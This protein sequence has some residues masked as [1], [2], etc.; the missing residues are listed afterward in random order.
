MYAI[1]TDSTD[2]FFNLALE[3]TLFETLHPGHPGMLLAW[4]NAPSII[5]GRHQNTAGEVNQE[6]CGRHGIRV[7]RRPT[8]GGAVY[9]DL[10]NINFS[11]LCWAEKNRIGGFE[12]YMRPMVR[13]LHGLGVDAAYTSRNDITV[14]GRKV[15]GTAQMQKGQKMLH[16][17]CLL[18]DVDFSMLGGALMADPEKFRSKSVDSH[19]ARVANLREFL[20]AGLSPAECMELVT[21][22]M[23]THCAGEAM[24]LDPA[25]LA[26][27]GR[28]AD[29]KYRT[30]EWTWGNSPRYAEKRRTR[31]PWGRLEMYLDV[32]Q[33]IICGCRFCGDFFAARDITELEGVLTGQ[34]ADAASLRDA[35]SAVP[36]ESWFV[37]ADREPLLDFLCGSG[38]GQ[39]L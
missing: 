25:I 35:L 34:K 23:L 3:E 4:R 6:F 28:L 37:G 2:P 11:F 29:A 19:R 7:V 9:H 21:G 15:A 8:G 27:A 12:E 39:A 22:A 5:V 30:W 36:V 13:A 18:V 26:E 16:H 20:P 31:F 1:R 38:D 17:G 24:E 33:G 32:Q 10:G 14:Q